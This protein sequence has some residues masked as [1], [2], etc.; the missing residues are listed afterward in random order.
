AGQLAARGQVPETDDAIVADGRQPLAAGMPGQPGVTP[1]G[2]QLGENRPG[3]LVQDA[4]ARSRADS[5]LR[6][7]RVV[8]QAC[9]RL[10]DCKQGDWFRR[11]EVIDIN[12]RITGGDGN[13]PTI[14]SK[15]RVSPW[16]SGSRDDLPRQLRP[17]LPHPDVIRL[18]AG[19]MPAVRGKGQPW[20]VKA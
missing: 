16:D 9:W 5:Q 8:G 2:A 12:R 10:V 13:V 4:N 7:E 1:G 3:L 19:E 15:R 18:P 14:A 20:D 11:S 6:L 17:D